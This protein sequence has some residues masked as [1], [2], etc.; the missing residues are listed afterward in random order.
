MYFI[1][2]CR[3]HEQYGFCQAGTSGIVLDDDTMVIGSP[4]SYTWRGTTYVT[5]IS[6]DFLARDKTVYFSPVLDHE[7]PVDKY[8]YL[9]T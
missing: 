2:F 7:A 1:L 5:S 3:G 9:G 8:S 6:S 4:G